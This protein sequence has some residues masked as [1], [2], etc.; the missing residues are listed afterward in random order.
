MVKNPPANAGDME[1]MQALGQEAPREGKGNSL[2]C[3]CLR[4]PKVRGTWW[5]TV[6][7][8]C[9]RIRLNLVTDKH[10]IQYI[11]FLLVGS[12]VLLDFPTLLKLCILM[13]INV[14][15]QQ[16]IGRIFKQS[17]NHSVN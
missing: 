7:T 8:G 5:A 16:P 10:F 13:F 4:N 17:D 2:Q 1:K 11:S 14:S 12:Y 6:H 15:F 3:T 9:K